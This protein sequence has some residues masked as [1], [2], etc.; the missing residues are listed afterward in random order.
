MATSLVVLVLLVLV[1]VLVL[2]RRKKQRTAKEIKAEDKNPV[3][4]IYYF[5]DG[6][7]IDEGR[8][9]VTDDNE[10]YDS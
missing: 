8:S 9:V 5:A 10:N 3:Y 1:L 2:R 4:G 6:G 7:N